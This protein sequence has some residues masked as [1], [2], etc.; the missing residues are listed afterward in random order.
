MNNYLSLDNGI[1][2][3]GALVTMTEFEEFLEHKD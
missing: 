2:K 3:I 1:L